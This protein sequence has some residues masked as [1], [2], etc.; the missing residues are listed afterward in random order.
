V[1]TASLSVRG[2]TEASARAKA[3]REFPLMVLSVP[4]LLLAVVVI[5]APLLWLFWESFFS[6]GSFTLV[7]YARIVEQPSYSTIIS[8]TFWLGAL[9]TAITVVLGYPLAYF[10]T[11]VRRPTLYIC[12][13][14]ILLPFWTSL[15]VR[16]YAWLVILQSHG[17][18]NQLLISLG[19]IDSPLQ[20]V[21]NVTGTVIG[22]V[23]IALPFLVLPL[24]AAMRTIDKTLPMA[25]MSLGATPTQAF[26][27][28]FMPLTLPAV[29]T[30]SL[31]VYVYCLGFYVAPEILGGG[32]VNLLA[33]KA[34]ENISVYSDWGAASA[35]GAVLLFSTF[36]LLAAVGWVNQRI[37]AK[38]GPRHE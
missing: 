17:P 5:F 19:L 29:G 12:I 30:G 16:T 28:T 2:R 3:P 27:S 35:L 6:R 1:N 7:N 20:L 33:Q 25:A 9:V 23:H 36:V 31:L 14:L 4:A 32:R 15:L 37:N 38:D 10:M 22:M 26:W 34:L 13:L 11:L 21:H 8:R 18:L 24:F